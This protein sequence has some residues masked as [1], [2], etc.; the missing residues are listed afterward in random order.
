M[1]EDLPWWWYWESVRD[2]LGLHFYPGTHTLKIESQPFDFQ[3]I[4][5]VRRFRGYQ[6]DQS[7]ALAGI[8]HPKR[9]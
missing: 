2:G 1:A 6:L 7:P 5:N 8:R 4:V 9:H 3:G